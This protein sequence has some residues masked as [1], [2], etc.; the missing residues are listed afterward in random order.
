MRVRL[1]D[2]S[3]VPTLVD[4]LTLAGFAAVGSGRRGELSVIVADDQESPVAVA[5]YQELQRWQELHDGVGIKIE[6]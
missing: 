3:L 1:D 6:P 2:D 5:L 4:D